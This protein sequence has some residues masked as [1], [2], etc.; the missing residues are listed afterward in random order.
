MSYETTTLKTFMTISK[1]TGDISID[2]LGEVGTYKI[3]VIGTLP[4]G[5]TSS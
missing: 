5:Q 4:N 3:V 1:T 2:Y